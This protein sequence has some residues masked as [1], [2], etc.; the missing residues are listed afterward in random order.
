MIKKSLY[1]VEKW[2]K[3]NNLIRFLTCG[4]RKRRF[5]GSIPIRYGI[6]WYDVYSRNV[7][8]CLK[9]FDILFREYF[10]LEHDKLGQPSYH[11]IE[12]L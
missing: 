6:I 5:G 3:Q 11:P 2:I 4:Q 1:F 7:W 8:Y 10:K 12:R 9:P